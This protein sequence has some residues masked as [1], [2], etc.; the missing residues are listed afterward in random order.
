MKNAKMLSDA[1]TQELV[2]RVSTLYE[3]GRTDVRSLIP[4][5]N[6]LDKVCDFC[7]LMGIEISLWLMLWCC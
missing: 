4:V 2:D 3:Q 7:Y 6:G 1:P 5:L